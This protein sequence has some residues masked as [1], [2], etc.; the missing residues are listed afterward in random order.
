M[1]GRSGGT[2]DAALRRDEPETQHIAGNCAILL[3]AC[4]LVL[5][6]D[7]LVPVPLAF[8]TVLQLVIR[9]REQSRHLEALGSECLL[10]TIGRKADALPHCKIM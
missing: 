1:M 6:Y 5:P 4:E 9:F 3:G 10:I 7:P 8:D 2:R